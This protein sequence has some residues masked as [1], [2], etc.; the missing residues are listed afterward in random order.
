[1][2]GFFDPP[3]PTPAS[4]GAQPVDAGL[5]SLTDAD[6]AAGLAHPIAA[7][8][9]TNL[10]LASADLG[11]YTS[12]A[13]VL[14][15]FALPSA[16]RTALGSLT[17][18]NTGDQTISL[19]GDVTG[20]GSGSFATTL[21]TVPIAKGGTGQTTAAAA[22]DALAPTTTNGDIISRAGGTNA[23]VAAGADGTV[24]GVISGLPAY[25]APP[26]YI[27]CDDV[28]G[29]L[30]TSATTHYERH[31]TIPSII[32]IMPQRVP[33]FAAADAITNPPGGM[34]WTNSSALNSAAIASSKLSMAAKVS[35]G[36]DYSAATQ[37]AAR[38]GASYFRLETATPQIFGPVKVSS[39]STLVANRW[40]GIIVRKS[41][42]ATPFMRLIAGYNGAE[43]IYTDAGGG[44]TTASPAAGSV[45]AGIWLML[46]VVAGV[47]TAYY[48]T[49]GSMPTS[50]TGWTLLASGAG[51]G[52]NTAEG[53]LYVQTDAN[54][55]TAFTADFTYFDNR[56][57]LS[58]MEYS[59][60][61]GVNATPCFGYA[62]TGETIKLIASWNAR[63]K[64]T[65]NIAALRLDL[66]DAIN[67]LPGD[68]AAWTF[69]CTGSSSANPAAPTTLQSAASLTLKQPGTD[70]AAD[71]AGYQYWALFAACASSG[72]AQSGSIDTALVRLTI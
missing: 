48:S 52:S 51:L 50:I 3:T 57:M 34:T 6:S 54:T 1:M 56:F 49:A 8:V 7:N 36:T 64:A 18:V 4:I 5:T 71:A 12:S 17:G 47:P 45:A 27:A 20:S 23:R 60:I 35:T 67:R 32:Q 58:S 9:W 11:I 70:T 46:V 40:A 65:P 14:A 24:L 38:L 63:N 42:S 62:A 29:I 55:T 15:P 59:P 2:P 66:A 16:A 72:G 19:T 44:A 30:A 68:A 26:W 33:I 25:F 41:G 13:G 28:V 69:G 22:F 37:T 61:I 10:P 53:F 39:A 31:A 21:A 43:R